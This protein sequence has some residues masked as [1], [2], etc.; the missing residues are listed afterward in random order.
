MADGTAPV[1]PDYPGLL[2]LEGRGYIV[3]GAGDGIGA[4]ISHALAQ[5]GAALLCVDRDAGRAQAIAKAVGGHAF[6]ADV[7][8]RAELEAAFTEARVRLGVVRGIVN[9]VGVGQ[10]KALTDYSDEEIARS[11]DLNLRHALM[12]VQLAADAMPEGGPITLVGSLAGSSAVSQT[13]VYGVLKAGL[14]H[15]VRHA[16]VELGPRGIRVNGVA[17]ASI[18]TPRAGAMF[19]DA[20]WEKQAA[21]IPLRRPGRP[22]EVASVLLFLCSDLSSD[23]NGAI[24]PIDGGLGVLSAKPISQGR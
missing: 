12:T 3:L 22:E 11:F 19:S 16:A 23:V 14:H 1:A 17:P 20:E 4:Q 2:S 9:I 10:V 21:L 24:I 5:C 13:L 18:R 8:V 15:L 7:T 6:A